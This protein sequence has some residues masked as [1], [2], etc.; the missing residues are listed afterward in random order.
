MTTPSFL[1]QFGLKILRELPAAEWGCG[2]AGEPMIRQRGRATRFLNWM[3]PALCHPIP[4]T[5]QKPAVFE[6]FDR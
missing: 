6:L 3:G 5:S 2:G 4:E 1:S